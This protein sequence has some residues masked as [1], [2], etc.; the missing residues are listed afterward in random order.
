MCVRANFL[1]SVG[2]ELGLLG[3]ALFARLHPNAARG[4]AVAMLLEGLYSYPRI[5]GVK[6][7]MPSD[8]VA[9]TAVSRH[10]SSSWPLH[11]SWFVPVMESGRP[12]VWIDPPRGA[13]RYIGRDDGRYAYVLK[14]GLEELREA[15]DRGRRGPLLVG[16]DEFS[17]VEFA[18]AR[19]LAPRLE[20]IKNVEEAI[21]AI[22]QSDFVL[23]DG[24]IYH[25]EVKTT[26]RPLPHKL[27]RKRATLMRRQRVLEGLGLKPAF[28]VITPRENWQFEIDL[29]FIV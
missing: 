14:L 6:P 1:A 23:L 2:P 15:V 12:A 19:E 11:K 3:E 24:E 9:G 29:E 28:V 20:R 8:E 22:E 25:V 7:E 17:E 13:V 4:R 21:S 18:V 27:S 26:L 10:I 5:R 16:L